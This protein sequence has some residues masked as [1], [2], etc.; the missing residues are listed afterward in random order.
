MQEHPEPAY[1]PACMPIPCLRERGQWQAL[2]RS[3]A[4]DQPLRGKGSR[5]T[6]GRTVGEP[7]Q[8]GLRWGRRRTRGQRT[9]ERRGA[10]RARQPPPPRIVCLPGRH[11]TGLR[12]SVARVP[13]FIGAHSCRAMCCQRPAA[14][15]HCIQQKTS[16]CSCCRSDHRLSHS[17]LEAREKRHPFPVVAAG[18]WS[19]GW[20]RQG[21]QCGPTHV[22]AT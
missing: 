18:A 1:L 7:G 11:A 17:L 10:Q 14:Y 2:R 5:R 16:H 6:R 20:R 12:Q 22:S 3:A 13:R 9:T 8:A 19:S 21:W 15:S 4:Q